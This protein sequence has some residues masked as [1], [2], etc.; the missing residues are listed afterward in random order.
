MVSLPV[1]FEKNYFLEKK[2]SY[3]NLVLWTQTFN[4]QHIPEQILNTPVSDYPVSF[5][6]PLL[7]MHLDVYI[8]Q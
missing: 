7:T 5:F 3:L 1:N 8:G 4:P 2:E 6:L